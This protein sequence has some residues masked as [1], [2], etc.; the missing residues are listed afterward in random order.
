MN[1]PHITLDDYL[2]MAG[3]SWPSYDDFINS[4]FTVDT[5]IQ[6]EI[7]IFVDRMKQKYEAIA[8][9]RT[10]E[11]SIANQQ[12]QKQI[13]FN[14]NVTNNT[15]CEIP[16]NTLG[17]NQNGNVFICASPSW[18]PIF[19]GNMLE[20]TNIFDILNSESAQKIRQEILSNRYF[21]CNNNLCSFFQ[22]V[23]KSTYDQQPVDQTPLPYVHDKNY[24]IDAIPANII[25]DFDYT[26]NFKCPS[27]RT[28]VI[29]WNDDQI[30]KPINDK[31]VER[32]KHEIIDK[33][34]TRFI[35][36]RWAGGEPFMSK[37][38]IELFDY[39]IISGKQNIQNIIQTNGSLLQLKQTLVKRLLPYISELRI[40][41]DAA[42]EETYK[43]IRVNG[44]WD[45]LIANVTWVRELITTSGYN[46]KLSA[47]FVVQKDNYKE[48]PDFVALC[49]QLGIEHINLQKMWNWGTWSQ[50]EFDDKNIYNPS[51][52]D[53]E[54]LK[55]Y[56][57]L[58]GQTIAKT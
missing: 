32:I 40:S 19:V 36:I 48:I 4:K 28:E 31:L 24:T 51:H 23:D 17:V 37:A 34:D 44:S 6:K 11:L 15:R 14:K 39:I 12:R 22:Q 3:S 49:T 30:I 45:K 50:V 21:Y 2:S 53:Y 7:N 5:K 54:D 46:T 29:N 58:A 47:D 26:C 55:K 43:K 52:P 16:W 56:F 9:P 1:L 10:I 13:F 35:T 27:C 20:T 33:I 38:Y 41:F 25:F 42:S 57:T 18:I 8:S